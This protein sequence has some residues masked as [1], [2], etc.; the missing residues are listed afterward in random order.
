MSDSPTLE[1]FKD[2]LARDLDEVDK[3]MRNTLSSNVMLVDK[4]VRYIV[5]NKGKSLRPILTLLSARLFGD[6]S[7][8][9]VKLAVIVELL[10]TATLVHDDVVDDAKIRR[11]FFSVNA[12][13]K[14]KVT[15]LVGDYLLAKA[16]I[17]MLRLRD[18]TVLDILGN[19]AQRMSRGEL[20]QISKVRKLDITEDIYFDMISDK[21]AALLSACC[22]LAVV[23]S[24]G[25]E[26]Q[27]R[28]MRNFG[29]KLGLAFQIRDDVLDFEGRGGIIG[30][31]VMGDV[32]ERKITLPL[33]H[34]IRSDQS[35]G[36][37]RILK[38]IERGVKARDQE[39]I[40]EYV[41]NHGGIAYAKDCAAQLEREAMAELHHFDPSPARLM[42]EQFVQFATSRKK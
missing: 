1:F 15:V 16:L 32:K 19:T 20:L 41:R 2:A 8:Q 18:F 9:V 17:E 6:P 28:A 33:I 37:K 40:Q 26:D 27:R 5:K 39:T 24:A 13:W 14:N 23:A 4:V 12:I 38:L 3:A 31:P 21:T 36:G 10:H 11:G 25:N 34:A 29:E 35:G 22:E 42:M 30:K 7:D